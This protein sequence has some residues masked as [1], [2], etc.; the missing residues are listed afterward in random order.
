MRVR[1]AIVAVLVGAATAAGCGSSGGQSATSSKTEITTR[2]ESF[3]GGKGSSADLQDGPTLQAAYTQL[4]ASPQAKGTSAK[5][6]DVVLLTSGDCKAQGI[7]SPC[8]KVTY[9]IL[10]GGQVLLPGSTGFSVKLN[11]KWLVAKRTFCD[12]ALL[13]NNNQPVQGCA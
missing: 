1:F 11:G 9:D 13:G 12:L 8:A 6:H 7:P 10:G 2:W 4:S 3:W 5:V